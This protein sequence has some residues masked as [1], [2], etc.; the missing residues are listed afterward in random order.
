M[1]LLGLSDS[2]I[3]EAGRLWRDGVAGANI[4]AHLGISTRQFFD[5]ARRDRTKFPTRSRG[6][7]DIVRV[8]AAY[9]ASRLNSAKA[10]LPERFPAKAPGY[11]GV[12][13]GR[14][15]SCSCEFPLWGDHEEYDRDTSLF[16]GAPRPADALRPYCGF[17]ARESFG[18]GTPS[19]RRAVRDAITTIKHEARAA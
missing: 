17:H 11:P 5:L 9:I 3:I 13:H 4:A 16:C 15:T 6:G 14:L 1:K 8:S 7:A 10:T 19:E 18:L 12:V 2:N